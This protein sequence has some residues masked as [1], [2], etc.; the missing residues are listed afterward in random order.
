LRAAGNDAKRHAY[1]ALRP[2]LATSG[3]I[4]PV[5]GLVAFDEAA[6]TMTK[7][8]IGRGGAEIWRPSTPTLTWSATLPC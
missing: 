8:D 2:Q 3:L 1:D 4:T 5:G 6:D 7:Q